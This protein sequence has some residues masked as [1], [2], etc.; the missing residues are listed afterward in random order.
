MKTN[1]ILATLLV[2]VALFTF[3]CKQQ[4]ATQLAAQQGEWVE[5]TDTLHMPDIPGLS[6]DTYQ[7]WKYFTGLAVR[8][9]S[10]FQALATMFD[11]TDAWNR[12]YYHEYPIVLPEPPNFSKY[13]MVGV[14]TETGPVYYSR[15]FYIND[16]LQKYRLLV[17]LESS[18]LNKNR[19][20]SQNWLLVPRLKQGYTVAFD[21]TTSYLQQL[22]EIQQ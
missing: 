16:T 1:T 15:K 14:C 12:K 7:T 19:V 9:T 5:I 3:G 21:T 11:T 8:D 2:A 10:E 6:G 17:H 20:Q 13:S 4:A 22:Q 18:S